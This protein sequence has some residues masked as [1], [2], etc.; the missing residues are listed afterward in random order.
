[1][2][3]NN[4]SSDVPRAIEMNGYMVANWT[5][6]DS[7]FSLL[8]WNHILTIGLEG[9]HANTNKSLTH[10][11]PNFHQFIDY[12]KGIEKSE[13][14]KMVPHSPGKVAIEKFIVVVF[15]AQRQTET[16]ILLQYLSVVGHSVILG[17]LTLQTSSLPFKINN[18]CV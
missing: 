6:D 3:A 4:K 9:F 18:S 16:N 2:H 7:R 13:G 8:L 1:M 14:S 10:Q 12:I 17:K 11:H 15:K 5:D